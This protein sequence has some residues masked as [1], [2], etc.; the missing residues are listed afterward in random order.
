MSIEA[1][2][3]LSSLVIVAAAFIAGLVTVGAQVAA[4]DAAAAAAR[5]AAI[6]TTY[7]PPRGSV[8]VSSDGALVTARA[9]VPGPLGTMS[10][11]AIVPAELVVE[12]GS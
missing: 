4:V 3:A 12:A 2:L 6:G 8:E 7:Q 10:A 9:T 5:A 1:A 11:E